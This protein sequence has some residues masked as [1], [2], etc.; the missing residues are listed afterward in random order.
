MA[1]RTVDSVAEAD[2]QFAAAIAEERAAGGGGGASAPR[3]PIAE[4]MKRE[5]MVSLR[6]PKT[7]ATVP[8]AEPLSD[9]E[10]FAGPGKGRVL[11]LG[12]AVRR[13][14]LGLLTP[15]SPSCAG[16]RAWLTSSPG[17]CWRRALPSRP[18]RS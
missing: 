16:L 7:A 9:A 17:P 11:R 13:P 15:P 10:W 14:R 6:E 1:G 12:S 4:R 8:K 18:T 3:D 5:V 2:A